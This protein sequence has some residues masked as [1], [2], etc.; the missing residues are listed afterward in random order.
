MVATENISVLPAICVWVCKF[1]CVHLSQINDGGM[2]RGCNS[3]FSF[4]ATNCV[5]KNTRYSLRNI[6]I[7]HFNFKAGFYYISRKDF[8]G[9]LSALSKI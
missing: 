7:M 4:T 2:E 6:I 3:L 8:L 9:I 1:M 5:Y